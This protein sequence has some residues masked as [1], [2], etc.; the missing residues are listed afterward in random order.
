M[1][2][3]LETL[4]DQGVFVVETGCSFLAFHGSDVLFDIA[5]YDHDLPLASILGDA[6]V[7]RS[8]LASCLKEYGLVLALYEDRVDILDRLELEHETL[9]TFLNFLLLLVSAVEPRLSG[10]LSSSNI[11]ESRALHWDD[12]HA[13][14]HERCGLPSLLLLQANTVQHD[15]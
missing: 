4:N 14:L 12:W 9:F 10:I 8:S 6:S 5:A 15:W 7:L 11:A 13:R 1:T 2:T 3:Y